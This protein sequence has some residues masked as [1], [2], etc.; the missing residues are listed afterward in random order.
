MSEIETQDFTRDNLWLSQLVFDE[1]AERYPQ[2]SLPSRR[3]IL[4]RYLYRIFQWPI[5]WGILG[6]LVFI[7]LNE[8][9]ISLNFSLVSYSLDSTTARDIIG[10]LIDITAATMGIVLPLIILVI[11]FLGRDAPIVIDI[12]FQETG[13][14]RVTISGL[15]VLALFG[16][17]KLGTGSIT[18]ISMRAYLYLLVLLL[19][20]DISLLIGIGRALIKILRSLS[21]DYLIE[22][23]LQRIQEAI[24]ATQRIEV[25][26]RFSKVAHINIS[27][28]LNLAWP[29]FSYVPAFVKD[30][31]STLVAAESGIISD[32]NLKNWQHL[33]SL[34]S[35]EF[36]DDSRVRGYL[37]GTASD[38]VSKGAPILYLPET[39]EDLRAKY[40]KLL[41]RSLKVR[42]RK[43][44]QEIDVTPLL[45]HLKTSTQS[46]AREGNDELFRQYIDIYLEILRLGIDLPE[47][48]SLSSIPI[49]FAGWDVMRTAIHHLSDVIEVAA[50]NTSTE[51]L[52]DTLANSLSKALLYV[53]N[54]SD[55]HVTKSLPDIL[56]LFNTM[57][58]YSAR[59][60][61]KR[62]RYVSYFYLTGHQ[63]ERVWTQKLRTS[64]SDS[65]SV[66]NLKL[67]L[68]AVLNALAK[69][70]SSSLES[71]KVSDLKALLNRLRPD[72]FLSSFDMAIQS[73][74]QVQMEMEW[75]LREQQGVA[76]PT[77]LEQQQTINEVLKTKREMGVF[78]DRLTFV[79]AS[80]I[81]E[82]YQIG[83][84]D[85]AQAIEYREILAPTQ[86]SF[87]HLVKVFDQ[88][89]ER[90]GSYWTFF[91]RHP[92]T[93]RAYSPDDEAKYYLLYCLRGIELVA[94]DRIPETLPGEN[95]EFRLERIERVCYE[96]VDES[97]RWIPLIGGVSN[98]VD[99]A[100][101]FVDI[102]RRIAQEWRLRKEVRIIDSPL[103][104][105]KTAAFQSAFDEHR[106]S[107]PSLG[108]LLAEH[109]RVDFGRRVPGN[110]VFGVNHL[111]AEKEQF[112]RLYDDSVFASEQG[113]L[114]S[115]EILTGEDKVILSGWLR[116]ARPVPT[117]KAWQAIQSYAERAFAK[118][119]DDGFEPGLIIVPANIRYEFFR[120]SDSYAD[121][122]AVNVQ[123]SL[124][125]LIG[126][127]R[128]VPV[129][130][131]FEEEEF[132]L[133]VDVKKASKLEIEYVEREI[134][135]V[136]DT[137]I[138]DI[139]E[140]NPSQ[141]EQQLKLSVWIVARE[142]A[143]LRILDRKAI[144]KL[145]IKLPEAMRTRRNL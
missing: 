63:F 45:R 107:Q 95:L 126:T 145:Q 64:F 131:W 17:A 25:L 105:V 52:I 106:G 139:I 40:Q 35:E 56:R 22:A 136:T 122:H 135:P 23:F 48:P 78:F 69:M 86:L 42:A 6:W 112:T 143:R 121:A 117:R 113:R 103:D 11:E 30:S 92:D 141:D 111:A 50:Q 85:R 55:S 16:L 123:P 18:T 120:R 140:E 119:R 59:Y 108:K 82:G 29:G 74:H 27:T 67:I 128:G 71:R 87:G 91:D 32:V 70:V 99:H 41:N 33:G 34:L 13:I 76:D 127:Y 88:L 81:F 114:C 102:N 133:V 54:N 97:E 98:L 14:R 24:W 77:L 12:Y 15:L 21:T 19:L 60:D 3:D 90:G 72:E 115:Q 66:S 144:V 62:G 125:H 83:E 73:V 58:H 93:K 96:L 68:S 116:S 28:T 118:L 49:L 101:R 79:V 89:V 80:F 65:K 51:A 1:V 46:A 104:P 10:S 5:I 8:V 110:R 26:N 39:N 53:V 130:E 129:L 134:R 84:I 75:R 38:V 57:Y 44:T 36:P 43:K 2:L 137:I 61:N 132:M 47:P 109:S 138:M 100:Q 31:A 20:L 94:F 9:L 4:L 124:P 142:K 37:I 7:F